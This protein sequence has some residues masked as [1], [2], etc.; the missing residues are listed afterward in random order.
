[1]LVTIITFVVILGVLVFVHELGHFAMARRFG[2]KVDEFGFG[3][4]PRI[5]GIKKGETIYSI[6]WIPLGG[7]VKIKGEGGEGRDEQDS[8]AAK[9]AW[10]R[11]LVLSAGVLMNFLLAFVLYTTGHIVGLPQ[12]ITDAEASQL[13][14][15]DS[16]VVIAEVAPDSA[17]SKAGLQLGDWIITLDGQPMATVDGTQRYIAEHN[18]QSIQF[19][20]DRQG[21]Q[22][23]LAITPAQLG[24]AGE[25]VVGIGLTRT[26]IVQYNFF[27][28]IWQGLLTTWA[29][30]LSILSAFG[31][32]LKSLVTT[33]GAGADLS[34][35]IG[36]AV[37]TGQVV[38]LGWSYVLSFAAILS[39]NLGIV[40]ILPFPALDGGRIL[41]VII[42]KIKGKPVNERIEQIAHTVGFSLL[43]ALMIFITY[44][45]VL[46]YGA[47]IL[48]NLKHI[49]PS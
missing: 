34:G 46:R 33:G 31:L 38:K 40:N 24:Q 28:A 32:L 27:Q 1:M 5:F 36:V 12:Q 15:R 25:P 29:V 23:Q 45:D 4:P 44:Q 14:L 20:V 37:I 48:E 41:F 39:I 16:H 49:I 21:S 30:M 11:V 10:K 13:Q 19:V 22:Q 43:I 8:F 42:E 26:A 17:A 18:K 3:F 6:N 7:F 35:P 9:P 2:I 47:K